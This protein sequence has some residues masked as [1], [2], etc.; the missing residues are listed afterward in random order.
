MEEQRPITDRQG[1][2]ILDVD[3]CWRLL[4]TTPVGRIAFIDAGEPLILPVT[5]VVVGHRIAF[6]TAS[7]SK[8]DAAMMAEPVGFEVD[9]YDASAQEGW[10][11]VVRG[12]AEPV[13]DETLLR[14]LDGSGLEPWARAVSRP[15]WIQIKPSEVT[16]RRLT[17]PH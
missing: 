13:Y 12:V 14:D 7:G 15:H 10:S 3:E 17:Q 4:A 16:G 2:E 1:L 9:G 6:R 5:H 8:L 11:V